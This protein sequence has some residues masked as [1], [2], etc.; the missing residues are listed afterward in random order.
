MKRFHFY[1]LSGVAETFSASLVVVR[2]LDFSLRA[3]SI[4]VRCW[5]LESWL[6]HATF[7]SK[8]KFKMRLN[9]SLNA[10]ANVQNDW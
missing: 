3:S 10:L 1:F 9:T 2:W 6:F 8:G 7:V 4:A 5:M